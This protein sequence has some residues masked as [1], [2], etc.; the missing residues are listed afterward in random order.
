MKRREFITLL[1][2]VAASWPLEARAQQ[3]GMYASE[4]LGM[5]ASDRIPDNVSSE[6][7]R[8]A[9]SSGAELGFYL[10]IC[11]LAST[12]AALDRRN[13]ASSDGEWFRRY[14]R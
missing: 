9:V 6:A 14:R 2:G 5:Y 11:E 1:G 13:R 7:R 10:S 3:P 4:Q 8:E 12:R